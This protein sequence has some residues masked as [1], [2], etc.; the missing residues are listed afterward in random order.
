[1]A[2]R[3]NSV[4]SVCQKKTERF[5]HHL[6]VVGSRCTFLSYQLTFWKYEHF[7]ES[8]NLRQSSFTNELHTNSFC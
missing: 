4:S 8:E 5:T 2:V 6:H 7:H 1:M 3:Q